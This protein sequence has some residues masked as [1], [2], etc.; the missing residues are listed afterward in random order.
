MK[1]LLI[2]ATGATGKNL[3]PLL[4]A[5][6]AFTEVV[7][8]S[9]RPLSITH[10]KLT[11]HIVEFDKADTWADKVK[12]DI[13]FSCLG[14]TIKAAKTQQ[15]QWQVDYEYQYAF[16]KAAKTNQVNT[17]VLV[18]SGF[19]SPQSRSFYTRM[20]GQL[21]EAI[22]QLGFANLLIFRPPV[23]IRPNSQRTGE[24]WSVKILQAFNT[25]G[26]F[27]S[28]KPMPTKTLATALVSAAKKYKGIHTLEAKDIWSIQ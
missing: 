12:G 19:A 13:A 9:R 16:A 5:D 3:L 6:T 21:E 15:A 8:F 1:A 2:G 7:V 18:S 28:M 14:T 20:K 10:E 17:F 24:I 25:I 22:K 27:K 11:V 23:L 4:L 26:L